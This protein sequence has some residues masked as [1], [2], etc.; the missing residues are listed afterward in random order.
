MEEKTAYSQRWSKNCHFLEH[1]K[2]YTVHKASWDTNSDKN[3]LNPVSA[4]TGKTDREWPMW[5]CTFYN[6]KTGY[7][8]STVLGTLMWT[9]SL[10]YKDSSFSWQHLP[11]AD[12]ILVTIVA[13]CSSCFPHTMVSKK[14][15]WLS[16][17]TQG[18]S[19]QEYRGIYSGLKKYRPDWPRLQSSSKAREVHNTLTD[20][21]G[22][23]KTFI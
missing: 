18:I 15:M 1:F 6:Q 20:W 4:V 8:P 19:S 21:C 10:L 3:F 12:V 9:S 7:D 23:H 22:M 11:S 17:I 2:Y 5:F 16:C 13:V 14:R